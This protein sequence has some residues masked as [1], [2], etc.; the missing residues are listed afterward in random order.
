MIDWTMTLSICLGV[1][2]GNYFAIVLVDLT[3]ELMRRHAIGR[4]FRG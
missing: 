1:A 2:F 4:M 3:R